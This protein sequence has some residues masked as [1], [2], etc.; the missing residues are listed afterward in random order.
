[1]LIVAILI[2][3]VFSL[4][5]LA[6]FAK[7]LHAPGEPISLTPLLVL[8]T[9]LFFVIWICRLV[10]RQLQMNIAQRNDANERAV[11]TQ[12]YLALLEQN[13][14]SENDR[15]LILNA[16]FRPTT[17]AGVDDGAPPHWFDLLMER[18]KPKAP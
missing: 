10:A 12:T 6:T 18:V 11:M 17:A 1:M 3:L 9:P 13:K 7:E 15:I 2:G 14:A 8:G 5:D 16:L 4:R